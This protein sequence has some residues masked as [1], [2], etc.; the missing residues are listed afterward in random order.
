M[1]MTR[2]F[3]LLSAVLGLTSSLPGCATREFVRGEIARSEAVLRPAVDRLAGDLREHRITVWE[4]G[5]QTAAVDRLEEEAT[6]AA[7]EALGVADVAAGRAADAVDHAT[8]ALAR[9]DEAG[10]RAEQAVAEADQTARRLVQLWSARSKLA[11][12]E[13]IVLRFG[14][15][16][17][18]LDDP[19]RT[20]ALEIVKRLRE[21]PALVVQLEGY[22]DGAGAPQHNLHLSQLRAEAVGRFLAEQGVETHRLQVIG[23][24]TARPV[25]DNGTQEGRR[26]NRRVVLRLLEPS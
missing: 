3:V 17:W 1:R 14:V 21:N 16:E 5:V 24:G 11:V 26:Q 18:A 20:A 10:T 6:R 22:A 9:A 23:L 13:A 2:W 7:I 4:L 8:L 25:A 15:D 19:A 12:V